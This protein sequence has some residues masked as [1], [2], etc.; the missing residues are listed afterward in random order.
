VQRNCSTGVPNQRKRVVVRS[1]RRTV[2]NVNAEHFRDEPA[3]GLLERSTSDCS[4]G[5]LLEMVLTADVVELEQIAWLIDS[6]QLAPATSKTDGVASL[7]ELPQHIVE[8]I[9]ATLEIARRASAGQVRSE[10]H[11]PADVAAIAR[12]ELGGRTRECV[13]VVVCDASNRVLKTMI[14]ARGS[15]DSAPVPVREILNVVL[16][17][18][19]RAFAIAHNHPGGVIEPSEADVA[20][21]ERVAAAAHAVGLRFLGHVVTG[22]GTSYVAVPNSRFKTA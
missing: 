10:I 19:G 21:T 15:A 12:R 14:V 20:V 2:S 5:E 16:R 13:L 1:G 9:A 4:T 22:G 3:R 18:D 11:G 7:V 8:V 6:G 17:C